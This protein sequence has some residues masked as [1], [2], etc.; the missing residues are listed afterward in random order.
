MNY[1]RVMN[2]R[3]TNGRIKEARRY[4]RKDDSLEES[5][6]SSTERSRPNDKFRSRSRDGHNH[7]VFR[8]RQ[9]E[10]NRYYKTPENSPCRLS[11]SDSLKSDG[12]SRINGTRDHTGKRTDV[13]TSS[14]TRYFRGR[15]SQDGHQSLSDDSR[16]LRLLQRLERD[17]DRERQ[18]TTLKQLKEFFLQVDDIKVISM[19]LSH[20]ISVVEDFMHQRLH[21]EV[22]QELSPCLGVMAAIL[23]TESKSFFEWLFST[24][25]S[26]VP[27]SHEIR[28][29]LLRTLTEALKQDECGKLNE[30][31]P[32]I[33]TNIQSALENADLPELLTGIVDVVLQICSIYPSV[34]SNNFRDTVD[35]IVGWHIDNSQS[36]SFIK[37]ISK[38]LIS[39]HQFWIADMKFTL[40][41]L[42]QFLEDMGAY[43]EDLTNVD[44]DNRDEDAPSAEECLAKISCLIRVFTTVMKSLGKYANPSENS[45]N[46]F[47]TWKFLTNSLKILMKCAIKS[48][49]YSFS[50]NL[51]TSANECVCLLMDCAQNHSADALEQLTSYISVLQKYSIGVMSEIYILSFLQLLLNFVKELYNCLPIEIVTN[52]FSSEFFQSLRFSPNSKIQNAFLSLQHAILGL[53]NVPVLEEAYKCILSDI[54]MACSVILTVEYQLP[55]DDNVFMKNVKYS[56]KEAELILLSSLCSLAEIGNAKHSIIGMWALKPSFFDLIVNHLQPSSCHLAINYPALQYGLLYILYSHCTRHGHFISSSSLINHNFPQRGNLSSSG[57][58]SPILAT[59]SVMSPPSSGHLSRILK[60]LSALLKQK[61]TSFD[62]KL[63]G[64]HW[65]QE[66]F[67]NIQHHLSKISRTSEI[68][69]MIDSILHLAYTTDPL[70]TKACCGVLQTLV[71]GSAS[72]LPENILKRCYEVC[73]LKLSD[74]NVDVQEEF[75]NFF[76]YLPLHIITSGF[77]FSVGRLGLGYDVKLDQTQ[78]DHSEITISDIW[79]VRRG[80]MNRSP[81]ST[82]H[83]HNFKTVMTYILQGIEPED[84]NWLYRLFYT[85]QHIDKQSKLSG[86]LMTLMVSNNSL[87]WF[88]TTWEVAQLCVLNKLRTPLGKPQETFTTIEG[89]IKSYA[90]QAGKQENL[91]ISQ[92]CN[93][94]DLLRVR[95]LLDIMEHLEKLMY[96]AYEGCALTLSTPP[97]TVRTFFRTNKATCLEWL[98]RVRM[99]TLVVA[100]Q[101]GQLAMALRQGY[102]LLEEMTEAKNTQGL[103]FDQVLMYVVEAL[104]GLR[105]PEAILGLYNW[106]KECHGRKFTWIKAAVDQ[107]ASRFETAAFEYICIL[108]SLSHPV[109]PLN[110][111]QVNSSYSNQENENNLIDEINKHKNM[112]SESEIISKVLRQLELKDM[113]E[114]KLDTNTHLQSYLMQHVIDCYRNISNWS[115]ALKWTEM[116]RKLRWSHNGMILHHI[117]SD[118]DLTF[119]KYLGVF[120]DSLKSQFGGSIKTNLDFSGINK[121]CVN[122]ENIGWETNHQLRL[123]EKTLLNAAVDYE[124]ATKPVTDELQHITNEMKKASKQILN[125]MQI[126]VIDWP[127]YIDPIHASLYIGCSALSSS[128]QKGK[129]ISPAILHDN[130]MMNPPDYCT[131]FL[132]HIL[133]WN[134]VNLHVCAKEQN[135]RPQVGNLTELQLI[136]A[137]LARK[138]QNYKLAQKLLLRNI[139]LILNQNQHITTT[140]IGTTSTDSLSSSYLSD[141]AYLLE[142]LKL[143]MQVAPTEKLI[144][145]QA[146]GAKLLHS[147]GETRGA[148]DILLN[149]VYSVTQAL[150]NMSDD[151]FLKETSLRQLNSR[152]LLTFVKYLQL[153]IKLVNDLLQ[154]HDSKKNMANL[155]NLLDMPFNRNCFSNSIIDTNENKE[156]HKELRFDNV[157]NDTEIVLGELLQRAVGYC[158]ILAKAWANL[159]SWCYRWGRKATDM[160]SDGCIT[161]TD[162]ETQQV[163]SALSWDLKEEEKDSILQVISQIHGSSES[164]WD[165]HGMDL[166]A[167]RAEMVRK[168][169]FACCPNLHNSKDSEKV[170]GKLIEIWRKVVKRVYRYYE[171][172]AKAYFQFLHLNSQCEE[173]ERCED[174]NVT[175]TLRLLRL[176]VKHAAELRD[177]LEKGLAETPTAPWRGIIPQLFSRLNHPEPYVRQSISDLLCRVA[178][179]SP[180]LI[181]FPAVVGSLTIKKGSGIQEE[182]TSG[183][184]SSCFS[185]DLDETGAISDLEHPSPDLPSTSSPMISDDESEEE[186]QKAAIM[187]NCFTA[188]VET[189]A[190]QDAHTIAEVKNLVHELRRITLLW[191]ELWVGTLTLHHAEVNRR[192]QTLEDEIKKVQGNSSLTRSEKYNIIR[193]KHTVF[194]KPTM[195]VLE[196]LQAI[197]SQTPETP[198]EQ[199]FQDTFGKHIEDILQKFKNP[200]DPS[201]PQQSWTLYK[202]LHQMLQQRMQQQ[203]RSHLLMEQISPVLSSLKCTRIPMPGTNI[204]SVQ[205]ITIESVHNN[206][207]IL[208]TKTKPK[209]LAFIGSDG[210]K[211]TYLFKGLEDLHLDERIMQFLSIVNN[212]FM[213]NKRQGKIVYQ[214]RHYSVT[215]L[216][217]RSGLIQWVDG[218]TPLFG[219]YKRWQQREVTAQALKNQTSSS[220]NNIVTPSILRP[221]EIYYNKLTPL[222][223]EKGITNLEARKEWPLTILLQ[224]LQELMNETPKDLLAKELWCCC[225]TALEWWEITQTYNHSTAVMSMIGYIIGLGDRH[226]DNV[227]VDLCSGEVVH[228]DY[229]VCFEKGKN[230][231]VPEKVPFRMTPNIETALGVTGIEGIFRVSCEHVLKV[232][233]K[234]RETLLTLLEAF[235]YDPLVDWTPGNEG[236][237]TGAVYGG[238][239][240]RINESGQTKQDMEHEVAYSMLSIR[241]AEMKHDWLKNREELVASLPKLKSHLQDSHKAQIE[242]QSTE[243]QLPEICQQ[244]ALLEEAQTNSAHSLYSLPK[245]FEEHAIVK[246]TVATSKEAV[247]EKLAECKKWQNLHSESLRSVCGPE[248][249]KWC[250]EVAIDLN[251]NS[252]TIAPVVKFLQ[253]AGQGQLVQ[254]CEHAESD[255]VTVLQQQQ[256]ALRNC[257]E[258]LTT[259]ATIVLQYPPSFKEQ[260]RSFQWQSWLESLLEDF[261]LAKCQDVITE[262]HNKYGIESMNIASI[263]A[264]IGLHYQLQTLVTDVNSKLLNVI[265][266]RHIEG[267]E[268]TNTL[269]AYLREVKANIQRY[270]EENGKKGLI[271]LECVIVTALCAL[272]RRLLIM[273][274]AAAAAGDCLVDLTSWGGDWYLDEMYSMSNSMIQL[275]TILQDSIKDADEDMKTAIHA[276]TSAHC[277]FTGLEDLS[278]NFQNIILPEA[279]KTV[280]SEDPSVL[281]MIEK[282][283]KII[284]EAGTSLD[285]LVSEL[286]ADMRNI[287]M[288]IQTPDNRVSGVIETMKKNFDMLMK[289]EEP[290][291]SDLTPG[292]MLLMG[293][294]G[295]FTKLESD[296]TDLLTSLN[297]LNPPILWR[298]VDLVREA[299]SFVPPIHLASTRSILYDIFFLKRLQA[300]QQFFSLCQEFSRSL[301]IPSQSRNSERET[302]HLLTDEQLFK[303]VKLFIAEYVRKQVLGLPSQTVAYALCVFISTL[304]IDVTAEIELRDIG[305]EGKVS[306][307][308]LSKKAVDLCIKQEKFQAG[309]LTQAST[310]INNFDSSWRK[311]D[312]SRR[313]DQ[314]VLFLKASLQRAQL[315]LARH[316]WLHED[317]LVQGNIG[318]LQN[319]AVPTRASVMSEMRKTVQALVSLEAAI[320][321]GQERYLSLTASVEQ[322][323]KWAAGANPSLITIQEDFEGAISEKTTSASAFVQL[324][325]ELG[326]V[327]NAILHFEALRTRTNEAL[328]SDSTFLSLINRCQ[329]SCMLEANCS[330]QVTPIEEQLLELK[331]LPEK[332]GVTQEWI[333]SLK[334]KVAQILTSCKEKL[335]EKK[336]E[337]FVLWDVV[338][339]D[340]VSIRTLLSTHHRYMS[341]IRNILR[342]LAKYE[343]QDIHI[344]DKQKGRLHHYITTYRTFSEQISGIVRELL[345]EGQDLESSNVQKIISKLESLTSMTQE[346]YDELLNLAGPM[347]ISKSNQENFKKIHPLHQSVDKDLKGVEL[348]KNNLSTTQGQEL[349]SVTSPISQ[350]ALT[351]SV[352][353]GNNKKNSIMRDPRTGKIIQERNMYA[354]NVWRRVKMKLDG[355][356]PDPNKRSTIAEQV[357]FV[358][359]EATNLENLAVLYEGWT[360]WV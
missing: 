182:A 98:T 148:T 203:T 45:E 232:L 272:N 160:T 71:K 354:T 236:G 48:T 341:E 142:N 242:L 174:D 46:T 40:N 325:R 13:H 103:E 126:S 33:M 263:Q 168:Q 104:I 302:S 50:E 262:F 22:K 146:E 150:N 157:M 149:S 208:P 194:M 245:R 324:S 118:S 133:A 63:L 278:L 296:M 115:D 38:A 28:I 298:K 164:E 147:W 352:T 49:E 215:P 27:V 297:H 187:Q 274:N 344:E 335:E 205:V 39:F 114:T 59:V 277:V 42:G 24:Y 52:V 196:Q 30:L 353:T 213:K 140:K 56:A 231:R 101:S 54:K 261:T 294:N 359:K 66:V 308:E 7:L 219:L 178:Q 345:S 29:L 185:E 309:Q 305:A 206:V 284:N 116:E 139:A 78:L 136:A 214:A 155:Q 312:L 55:I 89:A 23:G 95:L 295:L 240:G 256:M 58:T 252:L 87:L 84:K 62:S 257:V 2:Q 93:G 107:A 193:E 207:S 31:M 163:L 166:F 181:V 265:E 188:L 235:V 69:E 269:S 65:S 304:G 137:R 41:L 199:W 246:E 173:N 291:I 201:R 135:V 117:F 233:R 222:L 158:P 152:S 151:T 317:L 120:D 321:V 99:A 228:I 191:D 323:L 337:S 130:L 154:E 200:V 247:K 26:S 249:G 82:F 339:T 276:V 356:D 322:R 81:L 32:L 175:A 331:P 192:I 254:Q 320:T 241:V 70:L 8:S 25:N 186:Q 80:H 336:M 237:Y 125:M 100:L 211:Y 340:V 229:N 279:V 44:S 332:G 145:L 318:P 303:P 3:S 53:K 351:K 198:H 92:N 109:I 327:C 287:I 171:L 131:S 234:G 119:L 357:D 83:S 11:Q 251:I 102:Q 326:N 162:E 197:S 77:P 301:Q 286:E 258:L 14:Y 282:L 348:K 220:G 76:M 315:Q 111:P 293:F 288:E 165:D 270:V 124:I 360:P 243:T 176:V 113:S 167:D 61:E 85:S 156:L 43:A 88:W 271:S 316:Q 260:N 273:D 280:Q 226:L 51:L 20:I 255:L 190:R 292:Q 169:L 290:E 195:F 18:L 202:Q 6:R 34:F 239:Q 300:M 123:A 12:T 128:V 313:L 57:H 328:S 110:T 319:L 1:E 281:N 266:R 250:S 67:E 105:C 342:T 314:N 143:T 68:S 217:P 91:K 285:I 79:L 4:P 122:L 15:N 347:G 60:L 349:F 5:R 230:L 138:Q 227:L 264:A 204:K 334:E 19:N 355:R 333:L 306:L 134:I 225:S 180:H 159:A 216:G 248:L 153:D 310:L 350:G 179:A 121:V 106:C 224:V 183:I 75:S 311:E 172:S 346:V 86:M 17:D 132:S 210:N 35:I 212:M 244:R 275:I 36:H 209:K 129:K 268:D 338:K 184:F 267:I 223:K 72:S 97:K 283:N 90:K 343:E 189:L 329:E 307:E 259:Y 108:Y 141:T 96:N 112:I 330:S 170:I 218:A 37:Y 238:R 358:I 64:I 94:N 74:S 21:L 16:M 73:V 10:F 161:L 221:S 127:P 9:Q 299:A 144:K 177:V 47:I 289:G 253:S